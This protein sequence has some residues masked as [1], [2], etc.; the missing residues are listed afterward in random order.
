MQHTLRWDKITHGTAVPPLLIRS[1]L[2]CRPARIVRA[3]G[4]APPLC[5][6]ADALWI[7][8]ICL[9]RL[10]AQTLCCFLL[11]TGEN[12]QT[13][14]VVPACVRNGQ[15]VRCKDSAAAARALVAVA[16]AQH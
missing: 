1:N 7:V 6:C 4:R 10:R 5:A 13:A 2:P 9:D 12:T 14:A 15:A 8:E 11:G 3:L 16:A